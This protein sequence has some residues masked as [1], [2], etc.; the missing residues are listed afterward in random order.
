MGK[1]RSGSGRMGRPPRT[2]EPVRVNLLLPGAL[3]DWLA[4]R[5]EKEGRPQGNIVASALS[6]YRQQAARR[7]P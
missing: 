7:T 4:V 6:L 2:D 5:A 3:R 1:T